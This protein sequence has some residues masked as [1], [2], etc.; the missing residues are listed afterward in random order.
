[1][2]RATLSDIKPRANSLVSN[3]DYELQLGVVPGSG[4]TQSRYVT[5]KCVSVSLPSIE[6]EQLEVKNRGFTII[7]RGIKKF[8]S[9]TFSAEFYVDGSANLLSFGGDSYQLI[10]NW[11]EAVVSTQTGVSQP[12]K[13]KFFTALSGNAIVE[14]GLSALGNTNVFNRQKTAYA[15]DNV[16]LNV[17]NT[18]ADL[19]LK[20]QMN[21]VFPIAL[22]GLEFDSSDVEK[23]LLRIRA[24]FALDTLETSDILTTEVLNVV[25]SKLE[26]LTRNVPRVF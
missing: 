1:M 18:S 2:P 23:R 17:Y 19:I 13:S 3:A 24:T 20:F 4:Y 9:H 21:G 22:E 5:L 11:M 7:H 12:G 10:Y 15:V 26:N 25:G 14:Q 16:I 6:I 8:G